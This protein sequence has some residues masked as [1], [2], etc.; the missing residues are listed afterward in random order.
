MIFLV[1]D[2]WLARRNPI[3]MVA[4]DNQCLCHLYPYSVWPVHH[5]ATRLLPALYR[6]PS[7]NQPVNS[8]LKFYKYPGQIQPHKMTPLC[9][10][11]L[12][13]GQAAYISKP[14]S[15][16]AARKFEK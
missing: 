3:T 7:G 15:A 11:N 6:E 9:S 4:E 1:R 13:D 8:S 2:T 10:M 16:L 5:T 14:S 12:E